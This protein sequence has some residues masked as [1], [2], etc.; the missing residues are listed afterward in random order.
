MHRRGRVQPARPRLEGVLPLARRR[1]RPGRRPTRARFLDLDGLL[2][3]AATST[4]GSTTSATSTTAR[5]WSSTAASASSAGPAS[6]TTTRTATSTTSCSGSRARSS[7]S[8]RRSFLLSWH[9]Q[10][11]PLPA[12]ADGPRPVLS[13]AARGRR[14]SPMR[15]APEQPRRGPPADRAGLPR[16][17]RERPATPVRRSTRTSPTAAILRGLVEAGRRGVDVRV[18]VPADPHS[19]PARGAVRHW[20]RADA[21][22]RHRPPRAPARWPTRRSSWPTTRSSSGRRTS[23]R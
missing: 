9:F 8:S 6:R 22:R 4:G 10:G 17:G 11:G 5:S 2:G 15:A 13:A 3:R 23:T 21:R 18:I 16:G 12:T 20:F 14:D 19:L 7:P 1:R